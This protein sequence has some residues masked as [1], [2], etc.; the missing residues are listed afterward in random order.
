MNLAL[1]LY[2]TW[3]FFFVV[4]HWMNY[5]LASVSAM[6]LVRNKG[7]AIGLVYWRVNASLGLDESLYCEAVGFSCMYYDQTVYLRNIHLTQFRVH[8]LKLTTFLWVSDVNFM[9]SNVLLTLIDFML[10]NAM[11][12]MELKL[13]FS[14]LNNEQNAIYYECRV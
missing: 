7:Q 12:S 11:A 5:K 8:I 6:A 9:E 2:L 3:I 4:A 13:M 10:R 1:Y 14:L